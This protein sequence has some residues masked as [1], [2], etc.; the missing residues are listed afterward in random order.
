MT[1]QTLVEHIEKGHSIHKIA[2]LENTSYTNARYWIKK[3]RL[4]TGPSISRKRAEFTCKCGEIKKSE[5]YPSR[6]KKCKKCYASIP[7]SDRNWNAIQKHYDQGHTIPDCELEF[8]LARKEFAQAR[9]QGHLK[10]RRPGHP[11]LVPDDQLFTKDSKESRRMVKLRL[12]QS[13][14]VKNECEVCQQPPVWNG[15]PLVLI[16]DHK[17]GKNN[18]HR[19]EN[20]RLVCPNC[21]SQLP[22]FAKRNYKHLKMV[23]IA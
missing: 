14:T 6:P 18:D 1:K 11:R 4:E 19:K 15:L 9:K 21:N 10:T 2:Q 8:G 12:I 23:S 20:L 16:L 7:L 3:Y 22:T 17:N 13:N 5:F